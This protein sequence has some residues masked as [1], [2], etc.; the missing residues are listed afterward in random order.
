METTYVIFL[1]DHIT[2]WLS[3]IKWVF[4]FKAV[5]HRHTAALQKSASQISSCS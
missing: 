4:H 2:Q 3:C 1:P 5:S